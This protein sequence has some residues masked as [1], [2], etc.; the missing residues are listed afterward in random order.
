MG[1]QNFVKDM[2]I[3]KLGS[4][5]VILGMYWLRSY[6]PIV[7][8]FQSLH[9][10]FSKDRKEVR[11]HRGKASVSVESMNGESLQKL[12]HKGTRCC[13]GN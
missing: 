6:S 2:R 10:I 1:E 4:S 11:L 12:I 9:L 5:D 13:L 3:L 8:Y 7:F